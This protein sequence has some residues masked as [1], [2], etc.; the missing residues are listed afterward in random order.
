MGPVGSP[1]GRVYMGWCDGVQARDCN[2][3][4][5]TRSAPRA[6]NAGGAG[7]ESGHVSGSGF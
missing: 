7:R 5:A 4:H 6:E 1:G 3:V 2:T